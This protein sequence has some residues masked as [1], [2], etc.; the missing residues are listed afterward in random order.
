MKLPFRF[1]QLFKLSSGKVQSAFGLAKRKGSIDG[2]RLLYAPAEKPIYIIALTRTIKGSVVRNKI[3]RRIKA[4]IHDGIKQHG[5]LP[6]GIWLCV[7]Y[8]A[9]TLK[10]YQEL[11]HFIINTLWPIKNHA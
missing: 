2:I 11:T 10:S 4:I 3:R 5:M 1:S 6:Q 9:A 8:P 7:V